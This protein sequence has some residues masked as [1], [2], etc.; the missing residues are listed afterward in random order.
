MS[1]VEL[2]LILALLLLVAVVVLLALLL[3]RQT[4]DAAAQVMPALT[5][6]L[7]SFATPLHQANERTERELRRAIETTGQSGRAELQGT[8]ASFGQTLA[9][10]VTS[11]ATVQNNQLDTFAQT[12]VQLTTRNEQQLEALRSD[13]RFAREE[14]AATLTNTLKRFGDQQETQLKQLTE[15]SEKR[16]GEVRA[17]LEAKL[18]EMQ[19]DNSAKLEEM[20]KTV[21]EKL[22][23]TLEQRLGE[24]FRLVSERLEAV[25]RGL[26][27]MQTL[28]TG[29]GDL[30]RVLTNVKTRGTWGEVQLG[31]LL[32]QMLT[33]E[34]Y[35]KN[36]ATRPKSREVV[37][38]AVK[39]P[40]RALD[41]AQPVWLPIDSKF[42]VE[43]YERILAAQEAA[44]NGA[45]EEAVKRF[46]AVI[47]LEAKKIHDKYI[48]PPYTTDFAILFLPTEGLYAEALRRPGLADW[49]QREARVSIAGPTTL[50]ALLNSLQLGFR[51][52]A[53]EKRSSEVWQ[54]LGAVK[55]EFSKFGDILARTKAQLETVTKS[56]DSAE[57]RTRQM[58]RKLKSVEQLEE[59]AAVDLLAL[60]S[61]D[62]GTP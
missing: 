16:L 47:K 50:A 54:L 41:D 46:E 31:A 60:G 40:G 34:Q 49:V 51:T 4:P 57:F 38:F 59:T 13:A 1:W 11:V 33:A 24:S 58:A 7:H 55:G 36:V 42:P 9:T 44:D 22:H 14:N 30:K 19:T 35:A 6:V 45:L 20:R 28:A 2:A 39:L 18:K 26:G 10:Q 25:H 29:V 48:E 32:E 56:I 37:E 62:D 17:T 61:D 27:E 15:M 12:L 3:R 53:I 21:D 8:L 23:A 43:D 52:L 5:P